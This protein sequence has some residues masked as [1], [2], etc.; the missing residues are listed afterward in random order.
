MIES[1]VTLPVGEHLI[2][3]K[4]FTGFGSGG[5]YTSVKLNGE[6]ISPNYQRIDKG[7]GFSYTA[8]FPITLQAGDKLRV[9]VGDDINGGRKWVT[10]YHA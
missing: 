6:K 5:G 8:V 10:E 2:E 9:V 1:I 4:L 7:D 3:T